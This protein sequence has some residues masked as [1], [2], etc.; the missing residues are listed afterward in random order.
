MIKIKNLPRENKAQS[1]MVLVQNTTIQRR[2]YT[3]TPQTIPQKRKRRN[4]A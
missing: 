1:P 2:A 3:N 4:T